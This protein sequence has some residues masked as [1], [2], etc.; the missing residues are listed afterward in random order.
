MTG[1]SEAEDREP[2]DCPDAMRRDCPSQE[3]PSEE[4]AGTPPEDAGT[5]TPPQVPPDAG[6]PPPMEPPPPPPPATTGSTLWLGREGTAQD[7]LALGAAVDSNGDVLTVAQYELDDLQERQPTDNSVKLVLTRRAAMGEQRWTRSYSV[8]VA[9]TP[10]S[11]RADVNA[12]VAPGPEEGSFVA[13]D[14][15]GLVEFAPQSGLGNGAFVVRLDREGNVVWS[16]SVPGRD[17]T[18]A[19]IAVDGQGRPRVAFNTSGSTDFGGGVKGSGAVVVTYSLDGKAEQALSVG[20]GEGGDSRVTLT[21]LALT[22]EGSVVVGGSYAGLVRFGEHRVGSAKDG[23]PFLARYQPDGKLAW[24]KPLSQATG[25]VRDV[26]VDGQGTVVA[27]GSFLGTVSWGTTKLQGHVYRAS[28]FLVAAD[29]TG[30]PKWARNLGDGLQ[31][32]ALGVEPSGE[33]VV[34]GF[35]YSLIVDGASGPDGLGSAQP[36]ALRYGANGASQGL[37]LYLSD[38]PRA[39]GELYGVEEIR[40]VGVLPDGD[41][42]LFGHTDRDTDFGTGR[43]APARSD[44][45]LI[46]M[47]H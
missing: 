6:G 18:V 41:T 35:T 36:V 12:R 14:A 43:R 42:V 44:L 33:L 11:L 2:R 1:C 13:A 46:R 32:G 28:P 22:P 3:T 9:D 29:P 39:R 10:V 19:D 21:T 15:R 5:T 8:R 27:L 7:D 31:A 4:D 47:K 45:F 30:K 24:V 20:Q 16:A 37:R 25:M 26:G 23:S 40:F 17:V 34:A 38:P